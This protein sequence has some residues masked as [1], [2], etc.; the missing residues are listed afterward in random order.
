M[1]WLTKEYVAEQAK[2]GDEPALRCSIEHWNQIFEAEYEEYQDAIYQNLT[3]TECEFCALC[4]RR[5]DGEPC[6]S[7]N[8]LLYKE[9]GRCSRSNT[10]NPWHK[11]R[12]VAL[13]NF[14]EV[15]LNMR[16]TLI[17]VYE[18]HFGKYIERK[19]M[20]KTEELVHKIQQNE[21]DIIALQE[22]GKQLKQ[23]KEDLEKKK[24]EAGIVCLCGSGIRLI[25]KNKEGESPKLFSVY[26]SG[27]LVAGS[28]EDNSYIYDAEKLAAQ[29]DYKYVGKISDFIND[30]TV[31]K[32]QKDGKI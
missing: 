5:G 8:C 32:L 13:S 15:I 18:K 26:N 21:K 9:Y 7:T 28:W 22:V 1:N 24:I 30:E 19:N 14:K 11:V 31:K 27:N 6:S 12:N 29:F 10:Y 2:L 20:T 4:Q 3:G 17:E 23:Q 25:V 16:D